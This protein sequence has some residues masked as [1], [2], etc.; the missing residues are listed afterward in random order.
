M[1]ILL[2]GT[3]STSDYKEYGLDT[4]VPRIPPNQLSIRLLIF[5]KFNIICCGRGSREDNDIKTYHYN[6]R[7]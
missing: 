3:S 5:P 4:L 6:K 7:N 2:T 1:H